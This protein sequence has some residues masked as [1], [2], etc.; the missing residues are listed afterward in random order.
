MLH[1][2]PPGWKV[3]AVR[4]LSPRPS[5]IFHRIRHFFSGSKIG[6]RDACRSPANACRPH[7]PWTLFV[8]RFKKPWLFKWSYSHSNSRSIC[9]DKQHGDALAKL[10]FKF[11]YF[12]SP[13]EKNLCKNTQCKWS[14]GLRDWEL[15]TEMATLYSSEPTRWANFISETNLQILSCASRDKRLYLKNTLSCVFT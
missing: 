12:I 1:G 4:S 9:I 10:T 6:W 7:L 13:K 14:K 3:T 2:Q 11:L 15:L 5:R 8:E